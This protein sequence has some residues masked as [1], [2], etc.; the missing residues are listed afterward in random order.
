MLARRVGRPLFGWQPVLVLLAMLAILT[1]VHAQEQKKE[2]PKSPPGKAAAKPNTG[3]P[4]ADVEKARAEVKKLEEEM[5]RLGQQMAQTMHKL[6]QAHAVLAKQGGAEGKGRGRAAR[7]DRRWRAHLRHIMRRG[8]RGEA[9]RW[10]I[11]HHE[12][13]RDGAAGSSRLE[14]KVDRLQKDV[15]RLQRQLREKQ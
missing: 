5:D 13:D 11:R 12:R 14:E 10:F 2:P 1:P 9:F 8:D 6:R 3:K 15:E 4:A 7:F